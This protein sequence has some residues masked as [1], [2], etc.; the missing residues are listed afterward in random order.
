MTHHQVSKLLSIY[1]SSQMID[2]G[3]HAMLS[4]KTYANDGY[5]ITPLSS[6]DA[7]NE[8]GL[9]L[10][11]LAVSGL[12]LM[13][14]VSLVEHLSTSDETQEVDDEV[15]D[16]ARFSQLLTSTH[17]VLRKADCAIYLD[18]M[19]KN[20]KR[21]EAAD[22]FAEGRKLLERS[23]I[24]YADQNPQGFTNAAISAALQADPSDG[25]QK[26]WI[27]YKYI[28]ALCDSG[29][30][31]RVEVYDETTARL[32]KAKFERAKLAFIKRVECDSLSQ[33]PSRERARFLSS[34]KIQKRY[35]KP[36]IIYRKL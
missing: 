19:R 33:V 28:N 14:V 26:G 36:S 4:G 11:I 2:S 20:S 16:D 34:P 8:E 3:I 10:V 24:M 30:L 29:V 22:L 32:S 9:W 27:T 17:C 6:A 21:V 31:E 13:W 7:F 15:D 23:I 1:P 5:N 25:D 18:R 12:V 35:L